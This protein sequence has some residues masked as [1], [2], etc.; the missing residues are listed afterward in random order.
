MTTGWSPERTEQLRRDWAAGMSASQCAHRLGGTT[1]NAVIS[2]VHR[3]GLAGR[4]TTVRSNGGVRRPRRDGPPGIALAQLTLINGRRRLMGIKPCE[5]LADYYAEQDRARAEFAALEDVP[6]VEIPPNERRSI[7]ELEPHHCRW[8]I[9]DP[10][11]PGFHF[12]GRTR[13]VLQLP[14]CGVHNARAFRPVPVA[15]HRS[16]NPGGRGLGT[17]AGPT[18]RTY[19]ADPLTLE[20]LEPAGDA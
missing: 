14:Y 17:W 10:Q 18:D 6:E 19:V 16:P 12:C 8:P 5:T 3:I 1:R 15:E 13:P 11:Q 20:I 9:G 7:Q 4:V 2:K